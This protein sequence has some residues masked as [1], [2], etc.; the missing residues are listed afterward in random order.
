[1]VYYYVK[2]NGH[3]N[4]RGN[5]VHEYCSSPQTRVQS[6]TLL[7]Y[8]LP[9]GTVSL[10]FYLNDSIGWMSCPYNVMLVG[11]FS[12]EYENHNSPY[13]DMLWHS[14]LAYI[15]IHSDHIVCFFIMKLNTIVMA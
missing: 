11:S 5:C 12:T 10:Y 15:R 3:C 9:K 14:L 1:M 4:H 2:G 6:L 7:L 8:C 13:L